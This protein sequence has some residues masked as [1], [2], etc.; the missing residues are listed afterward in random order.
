[1]AGYVTTVP[2]FVCRE[3]PAQKA[4]N[5]C[6]I[7][8]LTS[9]DFTAFLSFLTEVKKKKKIL[10]ATEN[11]D[12]CVQLW[13]ILMLWILMSVAL[14]KWYISLA[15]WVLHK[16]IRSVVHVHRYCHNWCFP[17]R[18][19]WFKRHNVVLNEMKSNSSGAGNSKQVRCEW[20]LVFAKTQFLYIKYLQ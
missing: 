6:D 9:C 17:Q 18:P 19:P 4:S 5:F 14:K 10:S 8:K 3:L 11:K 16:F 20:C 15:Y 13:F 2:A 7:W 1:M 12:I